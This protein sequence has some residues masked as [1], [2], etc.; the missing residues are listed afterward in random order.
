VTVIV[1]VRTVDR[2]CMACDSQATNSTGYGAPLSQPKIVRRGTALYG[3]SGGLALT[4][5][6]RFL[7]PPGPA[8]SL[9]SGFSLVE[10]ATTIVAPALRAFGADAKL[11]EV[12]DGASWMDIAL[13]VAHG[14]QWCVVEGDGGVLQL[15][16]PF[17]AVG[18]GAKEARG[19]MW[20]ASRDAD[21]EELMLKV[22]DADA[23]VAQYIAT[24][25]VL[26][27]CALDTNCGPPVQVEWAGP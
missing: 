20:L 11:A 18:S 17:H 15:D 22:K 16:V 6:S 25:G 24:Q 12:R 19:A 14:N 8:V 10:W 2:V 5:W 9:P 21:G 3:V 4:N 27:A 7:A 13:M 1:A 26:A 23:A